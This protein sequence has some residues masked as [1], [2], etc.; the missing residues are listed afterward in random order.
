MYEGQ[1]INNFNKS[2]KNKAQE[3]FDEQNRIKIE[4]NRAMLAERQRKKEADYQ[5]D[6]EQRTGSNTKAP[7]TSHLTGAL[8]YVDKDLYMIGEAKR[9]NDK[10]KA[11]RQFYEE[12]SRVPTYNP[13]TLPNPTNNKWERNKIDARAVI[14]AWKNGL[15]YASPNGRNN[16]NSSNGSINSPSMQNPFQF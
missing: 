13:V 6:W 8:S 11:N 15:G 9:Y 2:Y 1:P 4:K 16:S 3:R 10:K 5:L 14:T 7:D 12:Q